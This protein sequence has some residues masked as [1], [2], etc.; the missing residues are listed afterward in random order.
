MTDLAN[1]VHGQ[2]ALDRRRVRSV[3]NRPDGRTVITLDPK[4]PYTEIVEAL[5]GTAIQTPSIEEVNKRASQRARGR[6]LADITNLDPDELYP[7]VMYSW[8]TECWQCGSE[9]WV[10]FE[11]IMFGASITPSCLRQDVRGDMSQHISG[12]TPLALIG[13]VTT[14]AGGTYLGYRCPEC[15]AVLGKHFLGQDLVRML[16]NREPQLRTNYFPDTDQ[17]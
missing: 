12:T 4:Q 8:A 11:N 9:S 15:E 16:A 14:A 6:L 2:E 13:Q 1:L 3:K 5:G 17:G 10:V 7:M